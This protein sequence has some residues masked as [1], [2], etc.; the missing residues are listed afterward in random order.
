MSRGAQLEPAAPLAIGCVGCG[1]E[2]APGEAFWEQCEVCGKTCGFCR[3]CAFFRVRV[4]LA[5]SMERHLEVRHGYP[6]RWQRIL[7][8]RKERGLDAKVELF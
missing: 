6:P 7:M 3:R 2:A 5:E 8:L 4:F 1:R